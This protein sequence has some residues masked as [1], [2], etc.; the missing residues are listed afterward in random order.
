MMW[1]QFLRDRRGSVAPIFAIALLPMLIA[2]GAAIDFSRAFKQRTV[3]QDSLDAAA[4]AAGKKL[5]VVTDTLVKSEAQNFY[6]TNV[7]GKVDITPSMTP[8]ITV[9]QPTLTLTTQLHVPTYFLGIIGIKEFV[10]NL[11]AQSTQAMGT[12]EVAMA[13]DN[14]GSMSGSKISTL[15]TAAASLATTLW[16]LGATS[17]KPNPIQIA[18]VPFAGAVNVGPS[19]ATDSTATWLDKTG[20]SPANA[21]AME[22][23]G[24]SGISNLSLFN[25]LN[26]V[27]WG[28]CVE[29]RP[30]PYDAT[31]DVAS[32]GTPATMFVPMFAPDE[33]DNWNCSTSGSNSCPYLGST[34]STRRYNGAPTGGQSYNN[35][36]PD[37]PSFVFTVTNANPAVLTSASHG[38]T[39]GTSLTL[40]TTGSLYTGLSTSTAYYVAA[41]G[42]TTNTFD[43]TTATSGTTFTASGIPVTATIAAPALFTSTVNHGLAVADQVT[44]STTGALPTGL[45]AGTTY[46]VKR[47]PST[48]TFS[49]SA[50]SANTTVTMTKASP[51]VFTTSAAHGLVAGNAIVFQTTGALYTGLTAGTVYYVI[52]TGLTTTSFRVSTTSGGAAVNTS[53]SQSG[54]QSFSKLVTTTGSQSGS[55]SFVEIGAPTVFTS[56]SHGLSVGNA[57]GVS[58]TG[59]LPSPLSA[60]TVYYVVTVPNANLFTLSTTSGGTGITLTG[61][62]TGTLS[63][64]PLVATSG[65]QSGTHSYTF[66][67]DWTCQSG[68]A[69]CAGTNVGQSETAAFAAINVSGSPSLKYGSSSRQVTPTNMTVGGIP[70]GPNFMCTTPAITPLTASS[71]TITTAIN[72]LVASGSTNILAGVMWAWRALSPS[73]PFTNGRAYSVSDNK[74]IIILMTDGENTYYPNSTFVKSW[75]AAFGYVSEGR[76]GT[77]S[78]TTSTLT[79]KMNDRTLAGC[80]AAKAAGITIYT[81]GFEI[82]SSTSS[83][84]ATAL[85]LLQNCATDI[86][87]YYDAQN[88]SALAAAFTAIGN[89]ISLLRLSM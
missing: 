55:H 61:S 60:S 39:A 89:D 69:G 50:A 16:G 8:T 21:G 57:I 62:S 70:G 23:N 66:P 63:F 46:Y 84:P 72:N 80:S 48:T 9:G 28:G 30:Q 47:V 88:E 74:K 17:T 85:A 18:I 2:T 51:A 71:G 86:N 67:E 52:S 22:A 53:G 73:A 37:V 13:L 31:D 54:T 77:T 58:S 33:P 5:G 35:Y 7:G 59:S 79:G 26:G 19:Y 34:N 64:V 3:I 76:L 83:D 1:I 81:V 45:T 15:K 32:T 25:G 20:V 65:S 10:F 14:S 11:T 24:A 78:T 75:Y 42:L 44:F 4:L 68:T 29:E 49:V 12:L 82:N 56:N 40:S 87:K 27:N 38:L 6:A 41:A 36:L 43:L